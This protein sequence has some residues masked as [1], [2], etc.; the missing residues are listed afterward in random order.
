MAQPLFSVIM[1]AYRAPRTIRPAVAS[2][3][4]QTLSDLE[5][6]VV[7]DGS[8]DETPD[9]VREIAATD[10][11][12]RL[13]GQ[14]NAGTAAARNTGIRASAGANVSFLDNDDVWLPGYLESVRSGLADHPEA[15]LAYADSWAFDD[16][17]KY[18]HRI[19]TL[20]DNPPV[21]SVAPAPELL[22]ALIRINFITASSVTLTREAIDR[23]GPFEV[24]LSGSDDWDMWLR[25]AAAGFAGVRVGRRPLVLLREHAS[26][27]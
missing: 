23:V 21:E 9:V 14:E 11:R 17:T 10:D 20:Q 13:I 1:P 5:L 7:D 12:V 8:G 18:V 4:A 3:L 19:T 16:R 2:V 26:S 15:G 25:I 6:I 27:Q 22:R 24:D